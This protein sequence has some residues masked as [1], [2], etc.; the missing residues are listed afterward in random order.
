MQ[1]RTLVLAVIGVVVMCNPAQTQVSREAA[2]QSGLQQ[3]EIARK[4][5]TEAGYAAAEQAFTA[6]LALEPSHARALV[7]R[8]EARIMRGV[9]LIPTALPS[10]LELFQSGMADMDR[11]VSIAPDDLMVRVTR[12][13]SY[14]EF[15]SYY[16]KHPVAQQDLEAAVAHPQFAS[17]AQ[18][19]RDHVMKALQRAKA[20]PVDREQAARRDRFPQV[21][22]TTAP[23]MA[24]A[25]V[26][27]ERVRPTDRPTWLH[28]IMQELYQA[29]GLM[30]AH[31]ATSF[32]LP[33]MFLIFAWFQNKQ[34]LNDFY[35][36]DAH[37]SWMRDRA[38]AIA[39]EG[40]TF[41]DGTPVQIG[42]ELFSVLP[43]GMSWGGGLVP[44]EV[45]RP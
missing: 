16:N 30:A 17:L 14:V 2:F 22:E 43:G 26:T 37:Q 34:A 33:G 12:G 35:Y 36:S 10:A 45:R 13:L 32:D 8:G 21:S 41:Y 38:G 11:A 24:V 18:P 19:L 20:A 31:S 6:I 1:I 7:H 3:L 40:T 44:H 15:P 29:P 23:I 9:I 25:S 27:L 4:A 28:K 5:R 42:I 39:G